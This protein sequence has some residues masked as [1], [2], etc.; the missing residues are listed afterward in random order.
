[1]DS[2]HTTTPQ[3]SSAEKKLTWARRL[4]IILSIGVLVLIGII[5]CATTS[6]FEKKQAGANFRE[7][8]TSDTAYNNIDEF[9]NDMDLR[10]KTKVIWYEESDIRTYLDSF[11]V[12]WVAQKKDSIPK[13]YRWVVGFYPM[14]REDSVGRKKYKNRVDFL[15]V[16]TILDTKDKVLDF[17]IAKYRDLYYKRPQFKFFQNCDTCVGFDAGH[18]WP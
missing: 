8:V 11:F 6:L 18:L 1:M 2:P 3:K 12:K 17:R 4:N 13:G 5:I 15:V 10:R 14:R 16:P 7:G 9:R